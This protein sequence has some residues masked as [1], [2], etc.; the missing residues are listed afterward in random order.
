MSFILGKDQTFPKLNWVSNEL[1]F[2]DTTLLNFSYLDGSRGRI[3]YKFLSS[4]TGYNFYFYINGGYTID[5]PTWTLE[6]I[7][8]ETMD[9]V[10]IPT[11]EYYESEKN[12]LHFDLI[13]T[14]NNRIYEFYFCDKI[15]IPY[16]IKKKSGDIFGV[17]DYLSCTNFYVNCITNSL[18]RNYLAPLLTWNETSYIFDSDEELN[19]SGLFNTGYGR[20]W[21]TVNVNDDDNNTI[22]F[23]FDGGY[24]K[25]KL[26]WVFDGIYDT[27]TDFVSD[28]EILILSDG[29][30]LKIQLTLPALIPD[31]KRIFIFEMDSYKDNKKTFSLKKLSGLPFLRTIDDKNYLEIK[32]FYFETFIG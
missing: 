29:Y 24:N 9:V 19:A 25:E 7:G 22:G 8:S 16:A 15:R 13:T 27:E 1:I 28:S 6:K 26:T 10:D 18:P 17:N 14:D 23:F 20:H 11:I 2:N 5:K 30:T 3:L 31:D 32:I 4:D 12:I 21:V